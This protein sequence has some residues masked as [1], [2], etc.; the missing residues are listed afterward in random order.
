MTAAPPVLVASAVMSAG[1]VITG[2]VLSVTMTRNVVVATCP[3]ESL[4]VQVTV[5]DPIGNDAPDAGLHVT[6]RTPSTASIAL[7]FV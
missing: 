4:D 7:G 1:T 5:V 6:G 3:V 2:G